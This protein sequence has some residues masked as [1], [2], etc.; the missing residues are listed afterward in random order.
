M[1]VSSNN[2]HIFF[3]SA[4]GNVGYSLGY[5][6]DKLLKPDPSCNAASYGFVGRWSNEGKLIIILAMFLGRLKKFILKEENPEPAP[7]TPHQIQRVEITQVPL[8]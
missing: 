4:F 3:C 5:S 7:S 6:C 8:P 1:L 2:T